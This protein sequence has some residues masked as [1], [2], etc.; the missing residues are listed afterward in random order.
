MLMDAWGC[1]LRLHWFTRFSRQSCRTG[2]DNW[3]LLAL[4]QGGIP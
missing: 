3:K 4:R 2:N 1:G